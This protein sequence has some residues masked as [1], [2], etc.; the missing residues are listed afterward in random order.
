MK[1]IILFCFFILLCFSLESF[2]QIPVKVLISI[3]KAEDE[4]RFDKTLE[5]L[6]KSADAKIRTRAA[7]A[8]GRIGDERAIPALINLLENASATEVRRMAAFALGEIE[9]IKAAD[10]ILKVLKNNSGD[11]SVRARATEAAGKIA[12]A[13]AKDEK[14]KVLGEAIL[15]VLEFEN[16]RGKQQNREVVLL[17]L[18]AALRAKP[19]ETNLVAAKFL[20]NMDA[21]IRADAANTLSRIRAKNANEALRAMI[22]SETDAVARANAARALGAAED[23][24]S[25][26]LLLE[27]AIGDDDSR[28][29][30]SAIRSLGNLKDAKAADKLLERGA[31]LFANYKK[32]RFPMPVEKNELLEIATVL[33]RILPNSND[34]RAVKF[35]KEFRESEKSNS[36]EIEVAFARV[37]PQSYLNNGSLISINY[38]AVKQKLNADWK[39]VSSVTQGLSEIANLEAGEENSKL[40]ERAVISLGSVIENPFD[41]K[42]YENTLA[43]AIPDALRAF[44]AFKT[45]NLPE[46]LR[47]Q[48]KAKDLIIRATAAE[49]LGELEP[50]KENISALTDAFPQTKNDKLNDAALAILD[51]L[52]KQ[53]KKTPKGDASGFSVLKLFESAL[54]SPDYLVRRKT[55]SILKSLQLTESVPQSFQTARFPTQKNN[56]L[57][58]F[59]TVRAD[60]VRAVSRKN[61]TV[62]AVFTT[63]KGNFTIDLTPEDAPLTVDNFIKL[64]KSNYFNGVAIHRVVP[65]FVM[66][67]GDPRGD[68]N[69]G[70][71]W[72][73]R[74]E[75]NMLEYERGAVGMALSGKDTGGSQWFVTHSPQP[76]LDGGY[77]VFGRVNETDMKIVDNL[78]R[79]DK[80]LS[81]KIVEGNTPQKSVKGRKN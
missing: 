46:I 67:D 48:L 21:R 54:D 75:I 36:P 11:N 79:G 34:E 38:N 73:I 66:Q 12:A 30:V 72:Q 70:P 71:G 10:A 31:A 59:R 1:K 44:A 24:E 51:A 63:E 49:L 20:T 69:G 64:A 37:S 77:T 60:Y 19:E 55:V 22:L 3:V 53:Y 39:A 52:E 62:K 68:G 23:K 32:S 15:D 35:L 42:D 74:C 2:A 5:D 26:N 28:V 78:V 25:F 9:S 76:H 81:V 16:G 43:R 61:G 57:G 27:A 13:N 17:G 45:N 7:L 58:E 6:M 41:F 80:I 40:R 4:L 50:N 8:S 14:S 29:R 33:G 56:S 65:N 47:G 18:T